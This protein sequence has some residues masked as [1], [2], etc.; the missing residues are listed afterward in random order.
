MTTAGG[1]AGVLLAVNVGQPREVVG[2]SG[3]ARSAIWKKPGSGRRRV[4]RLNVDGDGQADL[5]GHGGLH[6]A[7][8]VYQVDSYRH[9]E[10]EL[11]RQLPGTGVFGENFT[12]RGFPDDQVRIGDR[13]RIGSAL[14]EVSQPRVTCFKVG[15]RLGQPRMPALLV[16]AGRPGFYLRVLEEGDVAAGDPVVLAGT[17][18]AALT[19]AAVDA[20]LYRPGRSPAD[21][22]RAL[23]MPALPQGWK[24]SLQELLD[25]GGDDAAPGPAWAGLRP[26]TVQTRRAESSD[27]QSFALVPADAA[28]LPAYLPGQFVTVAVA[29]PKHQDDLTASYSLSEAA[30][31]DRLR[32]SVKR[33]GAGSASRRLHEQVMTGE[34]LRVAA[35]RGNFTLDVAAPGPVVLLSAGIGTTPLLSMLDALAAG[36]SRRPVWWVH[37]ARSSAEHPHAAQAQGLLDRLTVAHRHVHYTRP[38]PT[39]RPGVDFDAT[40]RLG[41]DE[42]AAL[43]LP[44]QADCYVCGP[45]SFLADV[46]AAL[47]ALGMQPDRI[48]VEAFGTPAPSGDRRAPHPPATTGRGPQ[49]AFARSG[50]TVRWPAGPGSLL[51]LAEACDVPADWSCRTGVCHRCQTPLVDGSV[52]Y[53]PEPVDPPAAGTVLL[54]CARPDTDL[55]L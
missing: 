46:P 9:W 17:D 29:G 18:P 42:L 6:R 44:A 23:A 22:E 28:P 51:E 10:S 24:D 37:V 13:Y 4:S 8:L 40:G 27:V 43:H 31:P 33:S 52:T 5:V 25:R 47:L 21:L 30:R 35:P 3:P 11:G 48:H 20:L 45:P 38:L 49:V 7:V 41:A 34:Q 54:C 15:L 1:A 12:V 2:P 53:D 16:A 36:A 14:F 50:L 39:D 55:D 19:V 26:F 32:I